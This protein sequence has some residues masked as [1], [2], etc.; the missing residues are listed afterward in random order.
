MKLPPLESL[1]F[2]EV[3]ARRLSV[4]LA[5]QELNVTAGAVSQQVRKLENYLG[6]IAC[7]AAWH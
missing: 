7:L 2:F 1:R 5:A 3:T 4:R 6:R